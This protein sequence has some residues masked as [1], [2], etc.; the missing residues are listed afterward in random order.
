MLAETRGGNPKPM[1]TK[2]SIKTNLVFLHIAFFL[3]ICSFRGIAQLKADFT[4]DKTG[5]CSPL[6]VSFTNKTSGASASA[7]YK[8]NFGNGNT[9]GIPNPGAIF[10]NEQAYT[11]TLT[12]ED[13]GQS[14]SKTQT[15]TV[16]Q[17]PSVN[18]NANAAKGCLPAP[19]TFTSNSSAG[20]GSIA[21]Y[22]WDF[23]DGI[24]QQGFSSN[25]VHTY[26]MAQK[27]TVM[28]TVTNSF[29]CFNTIQK[30]DIVEILPS[31]TAG[32][33]SDKRVL[34]KETDAVQFTNN[35][36]GPGTLSYVWDFGDGTTSTATHPSHAFNKK[37]I[38][39]V[40]LTVNS[41][42]G[43]TASF[44]Q[45][46]YLNVASYS[47]EF[48]V[49]S[50]I[51]KNS[52]ATFTGRSTP[53]PTYSVWKVND[54]YT[55]YYSSYLSYNFYTAGTYTIKLLNTFGTCADSA[56]HQVSVK[57]IPDLRGFIMDTK[58]SCGAPT[59]VS[60]KD[61][62][63][64]VVKWEWDF[65]YNNYQPKV[66]ST[67]QAPVYTYIADGGY[68][69][70]LKV[71]N[72]DGCSSSRSQYFQTI[73][74]YVTIYP[75][76]SNNS[77]CG[78]L[79]CSFKANASDPI[80]AYKWNFGDGNSSTAAEPAY[81]YTTPGTYQVSL[82]YTTRAG[83]TGIVYYNSMVV[84][85]KPEA[86][87]TASQTQVCGNNNVLFTS[88]LT[89]PQG[90][91]NLFYRWD[92]GDGYDG[93]YSSTVHA[94]S[95]EG[96]Y[97]IK[98]I[99]EN[100]SCSDTVIKTNYIKV[101]PPF[102]HILSATN[103]CN[104]SRGDVTFTQQTD[105]ATSITWTFGDGSI[106]TTTP[107]QTTITHTYTKS[108]TYSV[109]LSALNNTCMI[110][111]STVVQ[112]LLKQ[113]PVL[114]ADKTIICADGTLNVN[115]SP[116]DKNPRN[117]SAWTADYNL[118]FQYADGST[119]GS[120]Y[121]NNPY[122]SNTFT[123]S[124][125]YFDKAKQNLRVI[126]TSVGFGCSDTTNY[127]P[128][129]IKS[130]TA[131]FEVVTNNVC[132]KNP[133]VLKD[134][135]KVA[136]TTIQSWRWDFGDGQTS[137]QS[138]TVSHIYTTPGNYNVSLK[139]TDATG[140]SATST[141]TWVNVSGPKASFWASG[142]NVSLNSTVYFYNNTN[143]NGVSNTTYQWYINGVPFSSGY[144]PSYTFDKP[145]TYTIKLLAS[146]P[147]NPCSSE[148]TQTIVVNNFNAAFNF[149]TS[150]IT[151]SGCAPV[152][153]RINNTSINYTKIIWDFGDGF[154]LENVSF[155]SHIY[156]RAGKYIITL[157]AYGPNGL[158]GTYI[159]SVFIKEPKPD[160]E[161]S[162]TEGCIG[163]MVTLNASTQST[164]SY[165]WDFGDG[166]VVQT[167]D[168]FAIH[169]Y[170]VP[171]I[172]SPMLLMKETPNGCAAATTLTDKINIHANP[173]IT[174]LPAEPLICLGSSVTL[175]ASGGSVYEWSPATGLSNTNTATPV[176]SP[177]STTSYTVKVT[178]ALGCYNT[179][180]LKVTVI[181]P[182]TVSVNADTSVCKGDAVQLQATG[183]ELYTWINNTSGLN[184]TQIANPVAQPAETTEY[185]I[186]GSD[187][188]RCFTDTAKVT[189]GILPLPT[190]D[191]GSDAEVWVA[192]PTQLHATGS[193]DVI[194]WNWTPANYLSCTGCSD[195]ISTP[196]AQT[197]YTITVQNHYGCKASDNMT[198]KIF[199]DEARVAIP[200]GFTPNGDG[201]ND[202]F[203]IKGISI[204]KHL[205]IYN[206][207]G[208]K[209]FERNNFIGGDR[210]LCWDGNF[211]GFPA[212]EGT[213]VYFAEL[214]CPTGGQF[215]RKGTV[216]LLR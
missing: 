57:D 34:C 71:T 181:Q 67:V 69:V 18:F 211:N 23:G 88:S 87:F 4:V 141:N 140:C 212:A 127:V 68:D 133:V 166:S 117:N 13:G 214:E 147:T 96:T 14:S 167:A 55:G 86:D 189:I 83:C 111:T 5:G 60:F 56:V 94:F 121:T 59:K 178:D 38:Y 137:T 62:T 210:S 149:T 192:N 27:A 6:S 164:A 42:E 196:Q 139:V 89:P 52:S 43:C 186:T 35:S 32:F 198:V 146:D 64:T 199:C 201:L 150:F 142:N 30:K 11:V 213:Y 40:K 63:A 79:I 162:S 98:L 175:Q 45:T 205:V 115:V 200:N 107:G 3:C 157:F 84:Y 97:T 185:T 53:T 188:H 114:T 123:G 66:Q 29:G 177:T 184:N 179:A 126:S 70:F 24:A 169:Q 187:V 156:E 206:R 20:S 163:H 151:A 154:T 93:Y 165:M 170:T 92:F 99:V 8:W 17:K 176:A 136:N 41:S 108:G 44:I 124:L 105:N 202:V 37:G 51:C 216:T 129:Q 204:V 209:V 39:T 49:P 208:Q 131:G 7:V 109:V 85:K 74:P 153:V 120:V 1:C 95:K 81:T 76:T 19:I 10:I 161:T 116:F 16:Y 25:Q 104:G 77:N 191:A 100:G 159:D 65:S 182:V 61:T 128:L 113:K 195:P 174:L 101:L 119:N 207:W 47:T 171:G 168:S 15:I 143:T 110:T 155:P 158:T 197:T 180:P 173:V 112:V 28:L 152:L 183:A 145:G 132:F 91:A 172:Y 12:V 80:V 26:Y 125:S 203:I 21:S 82:N 130:A 194:N 160:V 190:V 134:T 106:T 122:W 58:D 144:S 78:T 148:Y 50:L 54:S 48:D 33:T 9:A 135:S 2:R 36:N 138:G 103:T 72:A 102:P 46:N 22:Y 193:P 215:A 118:S 73:R 90:Y 31:L 75:T